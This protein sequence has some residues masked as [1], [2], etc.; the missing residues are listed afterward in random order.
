MAELQQPA[1]PAKTPPPTTTEQQA[2]VRVQ[3]SGSLR[4]PPPDRAELP[5]ASAEDRVADMLISQTEGR[6]RRPRARA[7]EPDEGPDDA[8]AE[9]PERNESA[10]V[11]DEHEAGEEAPTE[12]PAKPE[13][14]VPDSLDDDPPPAQ[15]LE[16]EDY[17]AIDYT[18]PNGKSYTVPKDLVD[19]ALRQSDYTEKMQQVAAASKYNAAL[20]ENFE[21]ERMLHSELAPINFAIHQLDE[22]IQ[23]LSL[24]KY[25]PTT[26]VP[27]YIEIDKQLSRLIDTRQQYQGAVAKTSTELQG[28]KQ[29]IVV[30]LQTAADQY[31]SKAL[32]KWT[33]AVKRAVE[34]EFI[35]SG[36][37]PE[38]IQNLY[39]PRVIKA[40]HDQALLKKIQS[41]RSQTVKQVQQAA[42]VVRPQ[43]RA[44]NASTEAQQVTRAKEHAQRT[45]KPVDAEN[46]LTKMLRNARRR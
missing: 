36:F 33:P 37:T 18:A 6:S 41:K 39:D 4:P 23:Q 28:R 30:A 22:Q 25:A 46:A 14:S 44:N 31:L 32:P 2:P 40:F 21:T 20:R 7:A 19:G 10:A 1:A 29:A 11:R 42:P 26:T 38:E 35:D 12:E 8:P 17:E 9:K 3:R 24:Q 15:Q 45:G 16:G 34:Q 5:E 43:G 27:D 13:E